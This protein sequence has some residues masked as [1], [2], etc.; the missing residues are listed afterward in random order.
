MAADDKIGARGN[1]RISGLSL[2]E[3]WTVVAFDTPM[4]HHNNE[5]GPVRC[6]R[7]NRSGPVKRYTP[8]SKSSPSFEVSTASVVNNLK[9]SQVATKLGLLGSTPASVSLWRKSLWASVTSTR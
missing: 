7:V 3:L 8:D 2:V 9:T 6:C 5:V 4:H 1:P